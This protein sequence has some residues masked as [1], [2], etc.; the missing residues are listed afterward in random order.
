MEQREMQLGLPLNLEDL[1]HLP[2]LLPKMEHQMHLQ[3]VQVNAPNRKADTG[4]MM[5]E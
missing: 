5:A 1:R 4:M 2:P 3:L